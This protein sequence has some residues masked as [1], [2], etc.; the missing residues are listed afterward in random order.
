[1]LTIVINFF[2]IVYLSASGCCPLEISHT[3]DSGRKRTYTNTKI[4]KKEQIPAT[5][6]QD[7]TEPMHQ[8]DKMP[9]LTI[10]VGREPLTPLIFG[11]AI[12]HT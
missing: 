5:F 1:M 10:N 6:R 4:G 11:S 7:S 12:S 8:I 3:G 9:R 2:V